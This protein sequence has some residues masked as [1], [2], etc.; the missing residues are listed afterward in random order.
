MNLQ[1]KPWFQAVNLVNPHDVMFYNTDTPGQNIQGNPK[2][3]M[4]IAREPDRTP[5]QQQWDIQLPT[6]RRERFDKKGRP[7]A[8]KEYQLARGALVGNFPGEDVRWHRLLNYYF[9]CIRE[10]DG[11]VEEILDELEALGLAD[12]TIVVMTSDHGELGGSHGT[13]GKGA[14]TYREQNHV[15]LIISHPG[16]P[17][18]HGQ[19][20]TAVTSHL[21]LAPTLISWTGVN[22]D[23]QARITRDLHGKN[24]TPLL[25]SGAAAGINDARSGV[26]YCYNMFTI[27]ERRSGR[28]Q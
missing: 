28:H 9:N 14:T 17:G 18:T 25:E 12:N 1:G 24:L 15:P 19:R 8:H 23:K 3:L 5:Y 11:V 13:H 7:P 10:T 6:S 27:G 26:L 2:T 20:C 22:A 16:Y 4:N 21:D